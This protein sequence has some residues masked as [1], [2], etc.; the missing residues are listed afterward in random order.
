MSAMAAVMD[1]MNKLCHFEF[2]RRNI[3]R[4]RCHIDDVKS[5]ETYMFETARNG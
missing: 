4:S 5:L 3:W 2:T 1:L